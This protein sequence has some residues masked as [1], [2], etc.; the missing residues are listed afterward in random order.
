MNIAL[1]NYYHKKYIILF[2][3]LKDFSFLNIYDV[4]LS[5]FPMNFIDYNLST[6]YIILK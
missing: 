6:D 1:I 3:N 2:I 4:Y 5:K